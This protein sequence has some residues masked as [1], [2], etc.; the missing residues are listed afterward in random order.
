MQSY[1]FVSPACTYFYCTFDMLRFPPVVN[2][3]KWQTTNNILETFT[4][5]TE[6]TFRVWQ[7]LPGRLPA[8]DTL[9]E[10][11]ANFQRSQTWWRQGRTTMV[12]AQR[13]P[14]EHVT[15]REEYKLVRNRYRSTIDE[16]K[17]EYYSG[18]FRNVLEI[19]RNS[20][21]SVKSFTK[22]LQQ[23]QCPD[24]DSLKGLADWSMNH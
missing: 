1:V 5:H 2:T 13:W 16:A 9:F 11:I 19:K 7:S 8:E 15:C 6:M 4:K 24:T 12:A 23:E 18:K 14:H 3:N 20:S 17:T 22:P 10:L 21:K